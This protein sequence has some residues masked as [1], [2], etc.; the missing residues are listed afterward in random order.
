M[1]ERHFSD[2]LEIVDKKDGYVTTTNQAFIDRLR[3][4]K[5]IL[6]EVD[7]YE[8]IKEDLLLSVKKIKAIRSNGQSW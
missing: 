1:K 4:A 6:E 7:D 3:S 2:T 8:A 5:Y